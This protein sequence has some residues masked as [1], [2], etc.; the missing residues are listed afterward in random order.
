MSKKI[1]ILSMMIAVST[2]FYYIEFNL[3][4]FPGFLKYDLS[5]IP[6]FITFYFL[7]PLSG[8]IVLLFKNVLHMFISS[9]LGIGELVNFISGVLIIF[10]FYFFSK[11]NNKIISFLFSTPLFIISIFFVNLFMVIPLYDLILNISPEAL[12]SIS[13]KIMPFI[14]NI[15]EYLLFVIIPFNFIKFTMVIFI[16]NTVYKYIQKQLKGGVFNG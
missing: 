5:D 16:G 1:S 9:T 14:D 8:I 6:A 11:K 7:N 3:P 10:P 12:V 15:Y 2:I 4:I 13:S